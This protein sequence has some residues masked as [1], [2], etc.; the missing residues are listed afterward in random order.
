MDLWR[1]AVLIKVCESKQA[2]FVEVGNEVAC[3]ASIRELWEC[4]DT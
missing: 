3:T 1:Y 2:G 4:V